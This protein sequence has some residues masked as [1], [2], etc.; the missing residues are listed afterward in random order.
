LRADLN[1][2]EQKEVSKHAEATNSYAAAFLP[3]VRP[4]VGTEEVRR[5]F[6]GQD[7]VFPQ[8]VLQPNVY[9]ES[10]DG[11]GQTYD[12]QE[13]PTAIRE[14]GEGNVR[15]LR[16]AGVDNA[17]VCPSSGREPVEQRR[18]ELDDVVRFLPSSLPLAELRGDH[19]TVGALR[20]LREAILQAGTVPDA[21]DEVEAVWSSFSEEE[22]NRIG[23]G[24]NASRWVRVV[25]SPLTHQA[26]GRMGRLR[27]YGNA[28][29]APQAIAFV[30]SY[31]G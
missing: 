1:Q 11:R 21:F 30:R 29:V 22:K 14:N 24:F 26:T 28:L 7:R 9:G 20:A 27:A 16:Q 19:A 13:Q 31:V 8:S 6:G 5:G 17:A 25:A 3:G 15:I 2:E 10:H 23:L 18:V 4:T 12:R